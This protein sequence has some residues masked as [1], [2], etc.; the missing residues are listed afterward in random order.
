MLTLKSKYGTTSRTS[1]LK[2]MALLVRRP[3]L[4]Y[5]AV[6]LDPLRAKPAKLRDT[7]VRIAKGLCDL[8]VEEHG[9]NNR[10]VVVE[11]MLKHAGGRPGQP[12][13]C[14]FVDFV[15]EWACELCGV[16]PLLDPG[17]SCS[18]LVRQAKKK[19][20]LLE[21]LRQAQPG[22]LLVLKGGPTGYKHVGIIVEP[23]VEKGRVVTVE[24]NA[25]PPS[26]KAVQ[27]VYSRGRESRSG[28]VTVIRLR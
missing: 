10:G 4:R 13:C 7:I 21:D 16:Q 5:V 6:P 11:A 15:Y 24:G 1:S 12:W 25:H 14:A 8:G 27:G 23:P 20:L 19:G 2:W 22:D 17:L 18:A 26:A 3:G 28:R 9:G